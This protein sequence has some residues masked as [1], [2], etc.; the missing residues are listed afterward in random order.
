MIRKQ[1]GLFVL[2]WVV[3]GI[4]A[5]DQLRLPSWQPLLL[6]VAFVLTGLY[7]VYRSRPSLGALALC[8]GLGLLASFHFSL[9]HVDVGP[10]DVENFARE[11]R[12]YQIFGR[13]S[14]WPDLRKNRTEIKLAIDS[15]RSEVTRPVRGE[16]LLKVSDTTTALQRGDRVQFTARIYPLPESRSAGS[17]DYGR[18]LNLKGVQGIV[19][20]NTLLNLRLDRRPQVGFSNLVDDL[21]NSVSS[22]FHRNLSSTASALAGGFLIGETRD[23]PVEVYEMFRDSG[24][25]HLLAVSGSNVALVLAFFL[26][27]MRPFQ[28]RPISRSLML[29]AVIVVF[30]GLSYAEPSVVRASLMASLVIMARLLRRTYDLNNIIAVTAL[31]ILFVDPAQLFDV[32]F[33]LSFVTAWGLILLV[34][35]ICA[36]LKPYHGR[37]WYRAIVFPLTVAVVA[38]VCSTPIVAYYFGRVPVISVFANLLVVVMVSVGVVGILALLTMDLIWPLLGQMAGSFLDLWLNLIVSSLVWMGGENIPVMQTGPLLDGPLGPW[39]VVLAY[40]LIAMAGFAI[41]KKPVRRALIVSVLIAGNMALVNAAV[42]P[43][44]NHGLEV[45]FARVPGGLAAT[46]SNPATG[47]VDLVITGLR[48]KNYPLDERILAPWL[49]RRGTAEINK[50][51]VLSADYDVIDDILRLAAKTNC[52]RI[53]AP[54]RLRPSVEDHLAAFAAGDERPEVEYSRGGETAGNAPGYIWIREGLM[55]QTEGGRILFVDRCRFTD[56]R[57]SGAAGETLVAIGQKWMGTA[58][59]WARLRRLGFARIICSEIEQVSDIAYFDPAMEPD[60]APPDYC[61]DLSSE[62]NLSLLLPFLPK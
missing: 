51:L 12:R 15:L 4:V 47:K 6:S 17:F 45:E 39:W 19:Y 40:A 10:H 23:I 35:K 26:A 28:F 2:I 49:D 34:P 30:A 52:C 7:L 22:S 62:G 42:S 59:D 55:L 38:Q 21:R 46:V 33:Q 58:D 8:I 5:A 18:Y 9:R 44:R 11:S 1:P 48:K 29:L 32:G 41:G 20:L 37:W 36:P 54:E 13:V 24:T 60:L 27:V 16:V 53:V 50:I 14:D 61:H 56:P 25:L 3:I 57:G 43:Q 31:L